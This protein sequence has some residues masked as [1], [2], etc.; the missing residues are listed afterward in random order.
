MNKKIQEKFLQ[1]ITCLKREQLFLNPPKLN[2]NEKNKLNSYISRYEK[3]EP[4]EYILKEA[5]FYGLTFFVDKRVLIPR[6]DTEILVKKTLDEI[7]FNN[8]KEFNLIEIWIWSWC[9]TIAT[10][11]QS[12]YIPSKNI[13]SLWIDISKDALE[14]AKINLKKHW[15]EKKTKLIC[16]NLLDGIFTYFKWEKKWFSTKNTIITANLP[17]IKDNDFKNMDIKTIKY[18]PEKALYWW[19]ETWFELYQKLIKKSI[20]LRELITS[21]FKLILFI[22]IWFDQKEICESFLE[23]LNLKFEFFKDNSGIT[24]CVKIVF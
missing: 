3:W 7:K 11:K 1:K 10:L 12:L 13:N 8:Y 22:E 9:I 14:V 15:L 17:Y 2:S 6:D 18:E 23:N 21:D 20:K 19:K 24:R 4:I 5:E 16:W